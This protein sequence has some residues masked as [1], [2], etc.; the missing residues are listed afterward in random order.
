MKTNFKLIRE[1]VT[2]CWKPEF[3]KANKVQKCLDYSIVDLNRPVFLC[4]LTPS[5]ERNP[6]HSEFIGKKQLSDEA[7]EEMITANETYIDYVHLSYAQ[8]EE[9]KM[10]PNNFEY[11]TDEEYNEELE[12]TIDYLLGN[13]ITW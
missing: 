2:D 3:L 10:Y 11:E 13:P 4:E 5:V 9:G 1:N 7:W 6:Y 8:N 12:S